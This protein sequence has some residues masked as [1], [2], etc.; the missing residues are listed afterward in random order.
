MRN[1]VLSERENR[2][3]HRRALQAMIAEK[4]AELERYQTQ[5]NSLLQVEAEQRGLVDKLGNIAK[6]ADPKPIDPAIDWSGNPAH[7]LQA[8]LDDEYA[9]MKKASSPETRRRPALAQPLK[10]HP[11]DA[12]ERVD[13]GASGSRPRPPVE[14]CAA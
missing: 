4:T 6:L 3:Q 2:D 7:E 10:P 5:H 13:A 8:S 1:R 14:C 11:P 9:A 12:G